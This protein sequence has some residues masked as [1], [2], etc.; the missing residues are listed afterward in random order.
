MCMSGNVPKP[1]APIVPESVKRVAADQ[2][3]AVSDNTDA[4]AAAASAT[5][6]T[7]TGLTSP[8]SGA[9]KSLLGS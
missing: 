8:A 7:G 6:R 1:E 2:R 9:K 3:R 5:N 4:A